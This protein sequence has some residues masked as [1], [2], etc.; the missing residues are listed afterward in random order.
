[1]HELIESV[2]HLLV[3]FKSNVITLCLIFSVVF[4]IDFSPVILPFF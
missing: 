2:N 3:S 4:C 1:M